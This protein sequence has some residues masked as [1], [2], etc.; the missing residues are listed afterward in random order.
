MID[1]YLVGWSGKGEYYFII[2]EEN[3]LKPGN[4][5]CGPTND[6]PTA[7]RF[8]YSRNRARRQYHPTY[9]MIEVWQNSASFGSRAIG[10]A[11]EVLLGD[12]QYCW[13]YFFVADA[14]TVSGPNKHSQHDALRVWYSTQRC[15][16]KKWY[17]QC[18]LRVSYSQQAALNNNQLNAAAENAAKM[19]ATSSVRY[20]LKGFGN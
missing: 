19:A 7:R 2:F 14:V 9:N 5:Y 11:V 16:L 18:P 4:P 8:K 1:Y 10:G 3:L 20:L 15:R 12:R 13:L 17:S 6:Q